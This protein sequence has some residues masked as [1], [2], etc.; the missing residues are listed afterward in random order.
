MKTKSNDKTV[1]SN[2]FQ[3]PPNCSTA[4]FRFCKLIFAFLQEIA[5]FSEEFS[6]L[7]EKVATFFQ[8]SSIFFNLPQNLN[9][10][11]ILELESLIE[12]SNCC[13][14]PEICRTVVNF[15]RHFLR[16][17]PK[18]NE[19]F[20]RQLGSKSFWVINQRLLPA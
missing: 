18:I 4:I 8:L 12:F 11:R 3:G 9:F 10:T 7:Y 13:R 14:F 19:K 15:G 6:K 17:A 5:R 20:I 1:I 16:I 2:I